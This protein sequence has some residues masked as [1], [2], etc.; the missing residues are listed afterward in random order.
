[1]RPTRSTGKHLLGLLGGPLL[2]GVIVLAPGGSVDWSVRCGLGLLVWMSWWWVSGAV[3]LAITGLLPLV[4]VAAVGFAPMDEVLPAYASEMVLLLLAANLLAALWMRWGLDRRIALGTLLAF[5][6]GPRRQILAWFGISLLL[7]AILPNTLVA[8]A[9]MPIVA[10][11]L[12][13]VGIEDLGK[14]A[15]GTTLAL[16]VAWGASVG[17]MAT[18]LGGAPNLLITG[19]LQES[20]LDHEFRFAT[21]VT[22][23]LPMTLAVIVV[24][25]AVMLFLSRGE[26]RSLA[27]SHEHLLAERDRLGPLSRPEKWS[28]ALFAAAMALAFLRPLYA[29]LLPALHPAFAFLACALLAFLV[30]HQGKPLL[31]WEYAQQKVVWGLLYLFAGGAALGRILA[32]TG[33]ARAA[34]D[35]VAPVAHGGTL[36]TVGVI[37]LLAIGLTQITSNTAAAAILVPIVIQMS[38]GIGLDPVPMVFITAAAVNCGFLLPS[39]SGGPAI[40]AGYG[41]D[42]R[43]MFRHGLLLAGLAWLAI[44]LTGTLLIV[45]WPG[46]SVA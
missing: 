45:L 32:I 13:V 26:D 46:F 34:A 35:M 6:S 11:L 7:S 22:H 14:H 12:R 2:F 27:G 28:L 1:M 3:H 9:M 5:G 18:P 31:T 24:G 17:G 42:L 23:L 19:F 25:F 4:V 38:Q 29:T 10:A 15:L 39:S 41:I 37:A 20:V 8:A 16:A 40:A 36:I 43:A 30:S 33:T 21:W 44:T